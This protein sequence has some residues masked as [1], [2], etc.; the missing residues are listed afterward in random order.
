[1]FIAAV[2]KYQI[3]NDKYMSNRHCR[4]NDLLTIDSKYKKYR[5]LHYNQYNHPVHFKNA[6]KKL[7]SYCDK[8]KRY[9]V[10]KWNQFPMNLSILWWMLKKFNNNQTMC[11]K[12]DHIIQYIFT[13][14][15]FLQC[16]LENSLSL[17][18][19]RNCKI[20]ISKIDA[21]KKDWLYLQ[22]AT[23]VSCFVVNTS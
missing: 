1:M 23:Y 12:F 22:S 8:Q 16:V 7:I 21:F 13:R 9:L 15:L 19:G 5:L 3:F 2:L 14:W 20:K 6:L 18:S 17:T 10:I 4:L 11:F